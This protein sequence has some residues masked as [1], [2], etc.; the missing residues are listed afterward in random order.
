LGTIRYTLATNN[1]SAHYFD[2]EISASNLKG[3]TIKVI[4]PVWAPGSYL[5][6]EFSRNIQNFKAFGR[7]GRL[8]NVLK[9]AKNVWKVETKGED[10]C[11]ITY[12]VYAFEMGVQTSYLD[13]ERATV[14]GSSVFCYIDGRETENVQLE[15]KPYKKFK[16]IST[17]LERQGN[18]FVAEN[19]DQFI[20][21]PI[22]VGNQQ[23]YSFT[24]N[25]K[26]H[27][28]SICG[29]GNL[30]STKFVAD[31]KKI[32][33]AAGTVFGEYPYQ[34]Y[35]F[36]VHLVSEKGGGL[37][38][39]NS[40]MIKLQRWGFKSRTDYL[41]QLALVA[42]EIFHLW[43]VKRIRPEQ[44]TNY[45]YQK[46]NYTELLWVSEGLTS[47]YENE[48][49]RRAKIYSTEEFLEALLEDI[50]FVEGMPGRRVQSLEEASYDAWIKHYRQ[51]ENTPNSSVSYY[52]KGAVIGWMLDMEAKRKARSLDDIMRLLYRET[53]KRG[54][55]FGSEALQKACGK[56]CGDLDSF[57]ADYVRGVKNIDYGRWF[58]YAGLALKPS[59]REGGFLGIKLKAEGGKFCVASVMQNGPAQRAGIYA[60]DEIISFNGF[61]AN[62]KLYERFAETKP[63]STIPLIISRDERVLSIEI[64]VGEYPKLQFMLQKIKNPTKE[65]RGFFENW[66]GRR[67]EE[68]MKLMQREIPQERRWI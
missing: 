44:L 39:S 29:S 23:I 25:G 26:Q 64:K 48:I 18:L 16:K 24:I 46:E 42:H 21:S 43:N 6:R 62:E 40:S 38:H 30:N 55:G 4:M 59:K 19:Y 2:V 47:Y 56:V 37:E 14:N 60:N 17:G 9:T 54:R 32:V 45:D 22:E 20:D 15:I 52:A 63:D 5:V 49:L 33:G 65:Q 67:W 68:P 51:N 61:R 35:V 58:G 57:F 11:R 28:V 31:V 27:E 66:L 7:K 41:Q 36:I 1:P 3:N 12:R 53:Y 50:E 13:E 10:S 8:L 34:R